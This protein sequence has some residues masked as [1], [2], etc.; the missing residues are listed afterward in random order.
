MT[1]NVLVDTSFLIRL[2]NPNDALH[3]NAIGYFKYYLEK[4]YPLICS[5]I[6]IA[7]YCVKGNYEEIPWRNLRVLPFNTTHAPKAGKF[8]E[9]VFRKRN[10]LSKTNRNIIPNDTKL[11]AQAD[12]EMPIKAFLTSDLKCQSIFKLLSEEKQLSFE[13]INIQTPVNEKYGL[14][15]L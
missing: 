1:Y 12:V 10:R 3:D 13:I 2:L 11:F 7:E 9:M 8:A 14:L 6:S 4:D 15:G 5:T